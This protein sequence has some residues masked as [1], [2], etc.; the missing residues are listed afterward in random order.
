MAMIRCDQ[1]HFYDNT[2]HTTCPY[3]GVPDLDIAPTRPR[4][5]TPPAADFGATVPQGRKPASAPGD[6]A[7]TRPAAAPKPAAA[8]PPSS[9][10]PSS[11]APVGSGNRTVGIVR[12]AMGI[13]PVTGWLVC[14]Q[15]PDKGKDFRIKSQRN[16]IGRDAGQDIAIEGD[17]TISREKHAVISYDPK[18]N[19]FRVAPGDGRGMMYLNDEPVD[20]PTVLQPYD[21][22]EIGQSVFMFIPFC[23]DRFR[24]EAGA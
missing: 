16:F 14:V 4:R 12:K 7:E 19:S 3:C 13:D 17:E 21:R 23:G 2:K 8:P 5:E 18:S 11:S 10:A 1:G 6:T 20:M 15:G 9:P 24:W 22:I